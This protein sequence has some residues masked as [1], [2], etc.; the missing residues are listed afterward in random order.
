MFGFI[1]VGGGIPQVKVADCRFNI[2]QMEIL[3]KKAAEQ[4]V[5][6]ICFPEL[7]VTACTCGDL[8]FQQTLLKEAENALSDLIECVK[9]LPIVV[10]A[11]MSVVL[12]DRIFNAAIAFQQGKILGVMPK[13]RLSNRNESYE[14]RWFSSGADV[15]DTEI[16]LCKQKAA[17]GNIL[18][19]SGD[20]CI[21]TI[22]GDDFR[23]PVP[24]SSKAALAGAN[25]LFN[26]SASSEIAGKNNLRRALVKHRSAQCMAGHVYVSAGSGESTGDSVFSGSGF[27]C[28]NGALLQE[29][30]RFSLDNELIVSEI[31][32]EQIST[33]RRKNDDFVCDCSVSTDYQ[34]VPFQLSEPKKIALTRS[35][36]PTPFVPFE[37]NS[38]EYCD[39]IVDIQTAG[40]IKRLQ[41]THIRKVVLGVSGGLDSTLALLVC[42]KAFD[43]LNIPR[44]QILGITMPGFGTTSST[45][46]NAVSL[47]QSL[48]IQIREIDIKPACLQHFKDINHDVNT[49]DVTYENTQARERMQ[50][51]M[52][53]ANKE[54]G[55]V[56]GTGDLSEAALGWCT[57]NGDHISMYAV[58]TSVPKTLIRS[59]IRRTAES[60]TDKTVQHIL[61]DILDTPV[62][63][64]LLPADA[65]GKI[66]QK[67]EDILG[68]YELHDF[69]LYYFVH[70]GFSPKKIY[71][72]A[73]HAFNGKYE[74]NV[75]LTCLQIF[76]K[77][78]FSQQFKRSCSPDGPKVGIVSLSPRSD[79]KMPSDA[80]AEVWLKEIEEIES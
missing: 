25:L 75:I 57:Y 11:G 52:D 47:M 48:K 77:R 40:L 29:S 74:K 37:E 70:G 38:D 76:I 3:V 49:H 67:T 43:R 17:F 68:P 30:N 62:S 72:L 22:L 73:L 20:V 6:V 32:L 65:T 54:G 7:S 42:V 46:N 56:V 31:D 12:N 59:L 26:L 19:K 58:N 33:E 2:R 28:E 79:W 44:E 16:I 13:T 71:Y 39:E 80:S 34:I 27:I 1:K 69:F 66:A 21:G 4:E 45:Y 8:F 53:I 18:L 9:N 63:P 50:I 78:F 51:L 60:Q 36:S 24:P 35:I 55:L 64:E 15:S 5:Q 23:Q 61:I 10:I 41:H 14:K